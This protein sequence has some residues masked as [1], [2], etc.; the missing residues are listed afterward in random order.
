[1]KLLILSCNTGAGHNSVAS[2]LK[3]AFSDK[4]DECEI[5]DALSFLPPGWSQIASDMHSYI[6]KKAPEL[7]RKGYE[8]AENHR[9]QF[10]QGHATRNLIDVGVSKLGRFIKKQKYDAVLCS[11][12]FAGL[13]L[14]D[15]IKRY[16]LDIQS[17][18]VETD[19]T[20]TPGTE[21]S[22]LDW[23]FVPTSDQIEPLIEMGVPDER[24]VVSGIPVRNQFYRYL[25]KA[26]AKTKMGLNPEK[27]NILISC[28]SM[29]CGPIEE[30]IAGLEAEHT[31]RFEVTIICGSNQKLF[32]L[33]DS[34]Y[35]TQEYIHV[36]K[37]VEN[38]SIALDAAEV[39][40]TKP[41]G[42]STTEAAIKGVPMVFVDAVG[43]CEQYNMNYF[44]SY[45]GAVTEKTIFGLVQDA[46]W[47]ISNR[48][49][50]MSMRE[51]LRKAVSENNREIITDVFSQKSE[52]A[53]GI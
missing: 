3:E 22:D 18:I 44:L 31:D 38:M 13:M 20:V 14:S 28:G 53:A 8:H 36:L 11:H 50:Q 2:A 5:V 23:H 52:K 21:E 4:G 7:F 15:A 42:I 51:Q 29:G 37:K 12:V 9:S 46:L 1:M 34:R 39:Y 27:N 33:L 41:G 47:I 49:C 10:E 30:I 25:P 17:G 43:G 24:I 26:I 32:E 6:Y 19:Y 48:Q 35:R 16:S 45:G 40:I